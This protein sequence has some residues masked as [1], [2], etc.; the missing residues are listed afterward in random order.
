[1]SIDSDEAGYAPEGVFLLSGAN[2]RVYGNFADVAVFDPDTIQ[3]HSTFAKPH[4]LATGVSDLIVNGILA[5]K[6][7]EAT[8]A[9]SERFVHGRV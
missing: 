5:L 9:A 8:G 4:Q 1:M 2:P 7:G 3:D 6:G